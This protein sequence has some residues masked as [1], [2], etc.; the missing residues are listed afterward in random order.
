MM[1][2]LPEVMIFLKT[3]VFFLQFCLTVGVTFSEVH[4]KDILNDLGC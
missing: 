4:R 2:I 1:E 3:V